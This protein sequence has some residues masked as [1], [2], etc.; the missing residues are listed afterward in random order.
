MTNNEK[1]TQALYS[2][3][4]IPDVL[5]RYEKALRD[6]ESLIDISHANK[7]AEYRKLI[8]NRNLLYR[9]RVNF[10]E[11]YKLIDKQFPELRFSIDGRRKSLISVEKKIQKLLSEGRSLD[12]LRDIYAFRIILF[13]NN[14]KALIN[15]CYEIAN[16]IIKHSV[17]KGITICDTTHID[18]DEGFNPDEHPGIIVPEKSKI[19]KNF[20]TSVKDY[21]INPKANGYQSLHLLFKATTGELFEIQIRTFGMHLLAESGD[22]K[23]ENYKKKKYSPLEFDATKVNIPGF[24]VASNGD[25]FDMVGLEQSLE[26]LKRQKTY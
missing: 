10:N 21:I 5:E 1:F 18:Y 11:I 8:T 25:V 6:S 26:V 23:H 22:A 16:A 4:D 9:I 17:E 19:L 2:G 12:F 15:L 24:G 20:Q 14:T 13:G 3:K 7:I